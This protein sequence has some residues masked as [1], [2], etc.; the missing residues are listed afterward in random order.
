MALTLEADAGGLLA[1]IKNG[2]TTLLQIGANG[3]EGGTLIASAAEAQGLTSTKKIITPDMLAKAFQGANQTLNATAGYQKLPGGLII[4]WSKPTTASPTVTFPIAFPIV[5]IGAI[6]TNYSSSTSS[7]PS[8]T[9]S[10]S[11][12]QAVFATS[13]DLTR[14]KLMLAIGY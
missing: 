8:A 3:I 5:C 2:I 11:T 14:D 1:T 12:T 9:V 10:V 6:L 7:S 13:A 4:Q